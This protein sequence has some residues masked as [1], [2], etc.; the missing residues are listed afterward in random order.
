ME[1]IEY[2]LASTAHFFKVVFLKTIPE[3][4]YCAT[5]NIIQR[6]ELCFTRNIEKKFIE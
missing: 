5:H 1:N 2:F 6:A 4:M 3:I